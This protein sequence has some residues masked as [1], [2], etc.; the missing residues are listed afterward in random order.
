MAIKVL[1]ENDLE[2]CAQLFVEIFNNEPWNDQWTLKGALTYISEFFYTPNFKGYLAMEGEEIIGFLYGVKRSWWSGSEFYIHEMGVKPAYQ[3]K[4]IG[5]GLL[6]Y[7]NKELDGKVAYLS[8]LTDRGMPAESF[9]QK[10][11]FEVIE[12]LVF[13]SK[14]L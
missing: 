8:L 4:G 1:T 14:D 12:R 11:N 6:E 9:Y 5:S 13:Y 7:L 3:G 10:H 2:N